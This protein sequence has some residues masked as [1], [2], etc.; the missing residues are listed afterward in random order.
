MVLLRE[1][2][3]K[4]GREWELE[5]WADQIGPRGLFWELPRVSCGLGS[6]P[7]RGF[8]LRGDRTWLRLGEWRLHWGE[9][10]AGPQALAGT[11]GRRS[12]APIP[13]SQ[14]RL[15]HWMWRVR[16][17]EAKDAAKIL[18]WVAGRTWLL[19]GRT[20]LPIRWALQEPESA[21]IW[22]GSFI[23]S[24]SWAGV[25]TFYIFVSDLNPGGIN[26]QCEAFFFK[27][28]AFPLLEWKL[29]VLGSE[30]LLWVVL[31]SV[32]TGQYEVVFFSLMVNSGSSN[33]KSDYHFI[34]LTQLN[35]RI[36]SL[37]KWKLFS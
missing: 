21:E 20:G 9:V 7:E 8:Q 27:F 14:D 12:G 2:Y 29:I 23:Y 37:E 17:R 13:G 31:W 16:D 32:D 36:C 33:S 25:L 28:R 5:E 30:R 26:W 24:S 3:L 4:P 22:G 6:Q 11:Q 18:P 15:T 10:G 1:W 35:I 19:G 34:I